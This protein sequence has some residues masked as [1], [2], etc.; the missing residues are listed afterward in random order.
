MI[1]ATGEHLA[2]AQFPAT[3]TGYRALAGFITCQG[4]LLRV[5]VEGTNSYGAGLARHLRVAN[6]EVVEVIRPARQ[7]RRMRGKSDEIDAYAAAHIAL[8]NNDAVTPKTAAGPVEAIRVTHRG[9]AKRGQGPHRDDP[10]DQVPVGHRTRA[11][12]C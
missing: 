3:D 5:G 2:A 10:A 4:A 1:S 8:A 12:P 6:I 9:A 11:D 7:V